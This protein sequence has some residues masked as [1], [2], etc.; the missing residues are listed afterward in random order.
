MSDVIYFYVD[1]GRRR[2]HFGGGVKASVRVDGG[3]EAQ[4]AT[5][6]L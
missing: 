1:L 2:F 6:E 4:E 5:Q 3:E